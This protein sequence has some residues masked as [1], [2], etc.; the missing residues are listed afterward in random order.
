MRDDVRF[1]H[2]FIRLQL[3]PSCLRM[4]SFTAP[5]RTICF[6]FHTA[7][8]NYSAADVSTPPIFQDAMLLLLEYELHG[9]GREVVRGAIPIVQ[10][11]DLKKAHASHPSLGVRA[12]EPFP[13]RA[14]A[15]RNRPLCAQTQTLSASAHGLAAL[16]PTC[17]RM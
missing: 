13:T 10:R 7:F 11:E 9:P 17:C 14:S 8:A 16:L 6:L 4:K 2:G 5:C 1:F 12:R 15:V 3:A